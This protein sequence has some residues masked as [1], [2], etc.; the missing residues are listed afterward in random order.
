MT[1][2]NKVA[3][4]SVT[5]VS[6]IQAETDMYFGAVVKDGGFGKLYHHRQL[7]PID[8][9]TV[10]RLNRDT[11]YSA[12]IFDLDAGPV[13]ITLPDAAKRFRSMMVLNEDHYVA[14]TVYDARHYT[15]T[16]KQIGTRYVMAAIRTLVDPRDPKAIQQDKVREETF[17]R[18]KSSA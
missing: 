7:M 5:V 14:A 6:F 15:F 12:G 8:R 13:T 10:V 18:Q 4:T 1:N 11:L 2:V 16:R 17:A 3:T 9:Q